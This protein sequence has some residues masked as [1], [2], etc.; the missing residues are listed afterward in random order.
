MQPAESIFRC[1]HSTG[2]RSRQLRIASGCAAITRGLLRQPSPE[3]L[4]GCGY[5][6]V[7]PNAAGLLAALEG[8]PLTP[9]QRER[10]KKGLHLER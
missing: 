5:R 7:T 10:L 3:F 6:A 2:S 4:P 8:Q 9:S 1:T